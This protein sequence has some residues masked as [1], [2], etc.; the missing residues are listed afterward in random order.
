MAI[1]VLVLAAIVSC[2]SGPTTAGADLGVTYVAN[3]GFLIEIGSKKVLVDALFD[4][5]RITYCHVPD[6]SILTGMVDGKPPFE[7]ID[8][9]LVTHSH[10]DHF[11]ADAVRSM[12]ENN[13]STRLIAPHQV[14]DRLTAD[15]SIDETVSDR[16]TRVDVE[17]FREWKAEVAGIRV[18]A[19]RL[20][21]SR[22]EVVDPDTGETIDRHR[23]VV[24]M[25]YLI[26]ADGA[27][28]F[29]VGDA[30]LEQSRGFFENGG[31][32]DGGVNIAFLEYFDQ[33]APTREI[34]DQW[35]QPEHIVFMHLPPEND[36]IE[37]ISK[38][39]STLFPG[40]RVFQEPM[41]STSFE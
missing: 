29:H 36:Q 28:V 2:C 19:F 30:V 41:Q 40:S 13:P 8:L 32:P 35:V 1:R 6:N 39:L 17:V 24:N 4:D 34:L 14:T 31:F 27:R 33:S 23:D 16:I 11:S 5:T 3:E 37:A 15:P 9:V 26:E 22:Y 25:G 7:G 18:T 38:N 12:L 21:H 10:Q 20:P